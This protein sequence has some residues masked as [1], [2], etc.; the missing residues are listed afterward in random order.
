MQWWG[1]DFTV[2]VT[3]S[4]LLVAAAAGFV[5][6]VIQQARI[7]AIRT[8]HQTAER[9]FLWWYL[10]RPLPSM[11]LG[12]VVVTA[13]NAGLVSIGD[14]ATSPQGLSVLITA[15]AV[16]GLFTDA[17]LQ[18][19]RNVLGANDPTV[20]ASGQTRATGPGGDSPRRQCLATPRTQPSRIPHGDPYASNRSRN[21]T[22]SNASGPSTP[23]PFQMPSA[24]QLKGD[25][26][27]DRGL[28]DD[29]L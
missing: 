8:G 27:V 13:V 14:K 3:T 24:M 5:G 9:S 1:P 19:M 29:G 7:F 16:A 23:A 26:R 15:A 11:L 22:A 10:L 2:S 28:P 12:A 17:V 4:V 20:K 25:H 6:S 18:R 21:G